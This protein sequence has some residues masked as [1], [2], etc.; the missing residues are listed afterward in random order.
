MEPYR[1]TLMGGEVM[2]KEGFP[3]YTDDQVIAKRSVNSII[4]QR[5]MKVVYQPIIDHV[6]HKVLGCEA[7]SRPVLD[8]CAIRPDLWFRAAYDSNR[9]VEADLLALACIF[10]NAASLPQEA[11]SKPLFVNVMPSSL[12]DPSFLEGIERLINKGVCQPKQLVLEIIEY[13]DYVPR[14]LVRSVCTLRS[15]GIRIA[16][17]DFGVEGVGLDAISELH[18]DFVKVDKSLIQGIAESTCMQAWLMNLVRQTE[19]DNYTVI[20]EGIEN[21]EDLLVVQDT[22]VRLSQGY[23]WGRPTPSVELHN[24]MLK[25]ESQKKV[26]ADIIRQRNGLLTDPMVVKRSLELDS[27]IVQY[28]QNK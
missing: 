19:C 24:L 11:V 15:F 4:K 6:Q 17:D 8:G 14:S 25:I 1:D 5:S 3:R 23:H 10:E 22:G 21:T 9:S 27:L 18:P 13:I 16:L 20:A 7:L 12:G 28:H 26:L 2:K